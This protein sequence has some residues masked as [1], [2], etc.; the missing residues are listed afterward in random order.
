MRV[1]DKIKIEYRGRAVEGMVELANNDEALMIVFNGM[2]GGHMGVM[3]VRH[4]GIEYISV[5]EGYPVQ[6]EKIEGP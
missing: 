2:L 3:P 4:T 5:L 1:G 6:I